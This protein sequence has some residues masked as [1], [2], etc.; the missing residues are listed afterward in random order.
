MK[1]LFLV[2]LARI[3]MLFV[4]ALAAT[5]WVPYKG[6]FPYADQLLIYDLPR[7]ITAF[8][9]FDGLHYI[10]I[11]RDGYHQ[12]EQ[13]FFP[14]YPLLI[15]LFSL[16]LKNNYL[17]AGLA[18]SHISF[19]V[20]MMVLYTLIKEEMKTYSFWWAAAFFIAFPTSFFLGSVYT[21]GLFF[22]LTVATFFFL[23]KERFFYASVCA[24]FAAATRFIGVFLCIPF[25]LMIARSQKNRK[26]LLFTLAPF[27]GLSAYMLYLAATTGD[28]LSFINAQPIFGANRSNHII[29][30][31]QVYV[32]YL[33]IFFLARHDFAYFIALTEF[34]F[35]N[36][37]FAVCIMDLI[38]H[39]KKKTY[40][41]TSIIIFSLINIL[42]PTATG[43]L[44][45]IPRYSLLSLSIYFYLAAIKNIPLKIGLLAGFAIGQIVL[46]SLFIQGYF[47]S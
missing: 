5:K 27:I 20:G 22:A 37:I 29:L 47:I 4:L 34:I 30:L 36:V 43:T 44:S 31:P 15:K 2:M 3:G 9:N 24:L 16:F 8:A 32:R 42:L 21:E 26:Y 12:Y 1:K 18:I 41:Y 23:K 40:F 11:A 33:K 25:L 13:A 19:I 28:P 46:L 6:F 10:A 35:F 17:I 39:L 14:L 45:S 38:K 7:A